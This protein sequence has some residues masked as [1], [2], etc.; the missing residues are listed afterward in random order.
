MVQTPIGSDLKIEAGYI[1]PHL[2]LSERLMGATLELRV[3]ILMTESFFYKLH[4]NAK[5]CCRRIDTIISEHIKDPFGLF[6]FNIYDD[7]YMPEP[8]KG[9]KKPEREW[10]VG[11]TIFSSDAIK[12]DE[13]DELFRLDLDII[14][15]QKSSLA[16]DFGNHFAQA[17]EF[18]IAGQWNEAVELFNHCLNLLPGD[19]PSL[20]LKEFIESHDM[21]T[22][23]SW[24]G[25][26]V[27]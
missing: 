17:Y 18:Y 12:Y 3:P 16:N 20:S 1:S 7:P 11:A 6:T 5:V 21:K 25:F 15:M 8:K 10:P 4:P 2:D 9:D 27:V 14:S 19:G 26:R 24:S 22:P 23:D 13:V